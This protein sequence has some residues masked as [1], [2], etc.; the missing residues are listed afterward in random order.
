MLPGAFHLPLLEQQPTTLARCCSCC[1]NNAALSVVSLPVVDICCCP[2]RLTHHTHMTS[3][4]AVWHH[5]I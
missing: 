1:S 3:H 5:R 4:D 2:T